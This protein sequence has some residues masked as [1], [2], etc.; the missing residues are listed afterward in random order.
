M[1]A[2]EQERYKAVWNSIRN[3]LPEF[4]TCSS[5][6]GWEAAP[7]NAVKEFYLNIK[8]MVVGFILVSVFGRKLKNWH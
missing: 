6:V 4:Q 5:Y 2:K 7:R 8:I 3:I 1:T